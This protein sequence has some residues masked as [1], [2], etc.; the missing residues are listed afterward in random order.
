MKAEI[1]HA[2]ENKFAT[3]EG[4]AKHHKKTLEIDDIFFIQI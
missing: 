3:C 2:V 4:Y 1:K